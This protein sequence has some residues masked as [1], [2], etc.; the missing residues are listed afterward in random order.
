M[1]YNLQLDGEFLTKTH[2]G[3][4]YARNKMFDNLQNPS[5]SDEYGFELNEY[6][7]GIIN[8]VINTRNSYVLFSILGD[9]LEIGIVQNDAYTIKFKTKYLPHSLNNAIRGV[10]DYNINGD[11]IISWCSGIEVDSAG[12]YILNLDNLPFKSGLTA[13]KELVNPDEISI[14][15]TNPDINYPNVELLQVNNSGGDLKTGVYY[16]FICYEVGDNDTTNWLGSFNP[17]SIYES[18]NILPYDKIQGSNPD[19]K[20]SKSI[21]LNITNLDTKFSRFRLGVLAKIGGTYYAYYKR[22]YVTGTSKQVTIDF[23]DNYDESSVNEMIVAYLSYEKAQAMT[24][25]RKSLAIGGL[26]EKE[27][28]DYQKYANNI[29]VEYTDEDTAYTYRDDVMNVYDGSYKNEVNITNKRG[30][31]PNEVYALYIELIFKDGSP[32]KTFHIPGREVR[33]I[34]VLGKTIYENATIDDTLPDSLNNIKPSGITAYLSP[35][36]GVSDK[37]RFFHTR[38]TSYLGTMGEKNM[39]YWENQNERYEDD[40]SSDIWEVVGGIGVPTTKTLRNEKVRH[41]KF[42]SLRTLHDRHGNTFFEPQYSR[43]KILGLKIKN[44]QFPDEIKDNIQGYKIKYAKRTFSNSTIQGQGSTHPIMR[45]STRVKDAV[46]VFIT[47]VASGVTFKDTKFAVMSFDMLKYNVF[48]NY[49]FISPQLELLLYKGIDKTLSPSRQIASLQGC[50][51]TGVVNPLTITT[52]DSKYIRNIKTN[53]LIYNGDNTNSY[54]D[55]TNGQTTNYIEVDSSL[56][57]TPMTNTYS[58]FIADLVIFREDCYK[59]YREQKLVDCGTFYFDTNDNIPKLYGGDT[60][61]GLHHYRMTDYFNLSW[62]KR[63]LFSMPVFCSNNIELR[64]E[65]NYNNGTDDVERIYPILGGDMQNL[66]ANGWTYTYASSVE[67]WIDLPSIIDNYYGQNNEGYNSDYT[68]LNDLKASLIYNSTIEY[69]NIFL[70]RIHLSFPNQDESLMIGWRKFMDGNYK[71]I[72]RNKGRI[73]VLKA[74]DDIIYI[75]C[76]NS[77]FMAKVKDSFTT[78]SGE[79]ALKEGDIFDR[80][81]KEV[82]NDDDGEIGCQNI[83]GAIITAYGYIVCDQLNASIY[84]LKDGIKDISYVSIK[85]YLSKNIKV[86]RYDNPFTK[87][88]IILGIDQEF[89][90]LILTKKDSDV[91]G[92]V[93]GDD[94]EGERVKSFTF[95]YDLNRDYWLSQ[96][97]YIPDYMFNSNGKLYSIKNDKVPEGIIIESDFKVGVVY[98]HNNRD[99]MLTYYRELYN[100]NGVLGIRRIT[101]DSIVDVLYHSFI[102]E[103]ELVGGNEY[104]IFNSLLWTSSTYDLDD[105]RIYDETIDRVALYNESQ[106]SGE[107]EVN[108]NNSWFDNETGREIYESWNFNDIRDAVIDNKAKFLDKNY[109]FISTNISKNLKSWF[110]YSEFI[111]KFMV[112]RLISNKS[113]RRTV[114][115]N[116]YIDFQII[117]R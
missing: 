48:P 93:E 39:G 7:E 23:L 88:G 55:N 25:Y 60:F 116:V 31:M 21:D 113:N 100:N 19:I 75:Q 73:I 43:T 20:T 96:H 108:K 37:V 35:D 18:K 64:H 99:L 59:D 40:D 80:E 69:N 14:I 77:L 58:S 68:S 84:I 24:V 44:I 71:E 83:F 89:K 70:N 27:N 67:K 98:T 106:C 46:D 41:H 1:N 6:T 9:Y 78:Q 49:S 115:S 117:K 26:I 107:L 94:I 10:Y 42:P 47:S 16:P 97:S 17:I 38:D 36:E 90:R 45:D 63:T 112:A 66:E 109:N 82:L 4:V 34:S 76:E 62:Y 81:P 57:R 2:N 28:I 22:E 85:N 50:R 87:G 79:L 61:F 72:H 114:I 92:I 32:N 54:I 86:D 103:G 101:W 52:T 15:K 13:N 110:E 8:G 53:R 30:F 33:Q 12:I 104:K 91:I 5:C 95:S 3:V 56:P 29:Q 11:L 65:G 51:M 74:T 102:V 105:R 111:S